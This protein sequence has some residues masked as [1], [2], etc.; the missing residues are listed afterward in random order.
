MSA[1]AKLISIY[2][3]KGYEPLTGYN[4]SHFFNFKDAP[5]TIF[6]KD[7]KLH[8]CFGLALQE[9]M[10]LEGFRH[11]LKPKSILVIGNAYGWST[12]ALGLI[13]PEA[14]VI[15]IDPNAEGN[16]LTNTLARE[17]KINAM[18]IY[19]KSPQDV[20]AIAKAQ[21]AEQIDFFLIDADHNNEAVITDFKACAPL[22]HSDSLFFF[23]DVINW[24]MIDG[25]EH[26]CQQHQM[27][28]Q[29]LTRTPSGM[30][31]LWKNAS[32]ET[33]EYIS[34]FTENP[35]LFQAYRQMYFN[36]SERASVALTKIHRSD[37]FK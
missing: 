17:H 5:F 1:I 22:A 31:V 35:D 12:L 28:G 27:N 32:E 37:A 2:R 3:K 10:F 26:I 9:V 34:A 4:P 16:E 19:G 14:K 21:D 8:G 15:A 18:A 7:N 11:Y 30:A 33:L 24:N 13:F 6:H 23:H 25:F 20:S 29:I 36:T